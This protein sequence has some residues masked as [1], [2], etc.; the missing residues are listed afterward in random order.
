MESKPEKMKLQF[1]IAKEDFD[2]FE[3]LRKNQ[4]CSTS[5]QYLLYEILKAWLKDPKIE[6]AE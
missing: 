6:S 2:A 3:S 1:I 5:R 4:F